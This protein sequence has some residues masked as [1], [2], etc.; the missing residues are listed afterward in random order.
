MTHAKRRKQL[1]ARVT[2]YLA[3][4]LTR[5]AWCERNGFRE[6]QLRY[7]LR[8]ARETGYIDK[9]GR[10]WACVELEEDADPV[11][12]GEMIGVAACDA[13]VMMRVGAV[14]I[15]VCP[16]FEPSLLREVL[17]VVVSTC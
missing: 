10:S 3:S 7:W 6:D 8:K 2:D 14:T 1:Q 12:S 4:G 5:L 17:A 15:E 13:R 16:G 11:I 9:T